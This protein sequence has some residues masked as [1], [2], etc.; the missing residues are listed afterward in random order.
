MQMTEQRSQVLVLRLSLLELQKELLAY[1]K[2]QFDRESG[3]ISQPAEWLQ[4]IMISERF[5]W[6]RELT[7][8][9]IDTDIL[10]ELDEV[11]QQNAAV[12]ASEVER[13]LLGN[14]EDRSE[15]N[16]QYKILLKGGAPLLENL[17]RLRAAHQ[18]LPT[19]PVK[20]E[21]ALRVRSTWHEE[22]RQQSRK[23]RN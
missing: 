8:L 14:N 17:S 1:L 22:H 23:R 20:D 15:F 5:H 13:V 2:E 4:V 11:T 19:L 12:V 7:S 16:K 21:E 3:R 18:V 9:I 10:T 6:M